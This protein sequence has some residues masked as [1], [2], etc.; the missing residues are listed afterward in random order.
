MTDSKGQCFTVNTIPN[1]NCLTAACEITITISNSSI[2][3]PYT[4][5][6]VPAGIQGVTSSNVFTLTNIPFLPNYNI[7]VSGTGSCSVFGQ[8]YYANP[9]A[10]ANIT[11]TQ[12]NVTCPG[13]NNGAAMAAFSGVGPY[14]WQW[15][16]GSTNASISGLPAGG[17]TVTISDSRH[18]VATRSFA[19]SEPA[20]ILSQFATTLIPCY[21]AK[22]NSTITTTGGSSPFSYTLNGQPVTGSLV[23]SLGAGVHTIQTRDG[24]GCARTAT[25]QLNQV[26]QQVITPTVASPS[27]PGDSDGSIG[28]SVSGPVT[29]YSYSWQPVSSTATMVTGLVPGH[30]TLEVTDASSCITTSVITLPPAASLTPFPLIK[31]ENCSAVDG[32]FTMMVSGGQAPYSYTTFPGNAGGNAVSGLSSGSYTTVIRD[33]R[34]CVDSVRF[35]L[36]NLSTVSLHIQTITAVQCYST[37][38]GSVLLNVQNGI[39]PVSYSLSGLPSTTNP[40]VSGLCSGRY[41]VRAIDNIG[42]PAFD[43]IYFPEPPAFSY[44]AQVPPTICVGRPAQLQGAASGGNGALTYIWTPGNHTGSVVS[45]SPAANSV[46]S[47]NVYDAK[48]CS[49]PSYTVMVTVNPPI[50][51]QISRSDAGICPGTTAQISPTVSGGDGNYTYLWQPGQDKSPSIFVQN[52]TVPVYTLTVNDACGSPPARKEIAIKLHP[53]TRPLYREEGH[54]GCMP[55]CATFINTTPGARDAVW[56]YGDKPSEQRGDTSFYCY[57][58]AGV[59]NLRLTVTDSNACRASYTYTG[60][61]EVLQRPR[62]GF[63]TEP[64]T[65]TLNNAENVLMKNTSREA[66]SFRWFVDDQFLGAERNERYT[67]RDTG[68]YTLK[69]VAGNINGC[70]DSTMRSICVFEGFNFYMP[71]AFTPNNDGINDILLPKGTGWLYENYSLEIYNRWG[72]RVFVTT[73]VHE[74]WDGVV[75]SDPFHL[76][77]IEAYMNDVYTW[78]VLVTDNMQQ[79][80]ELRGSVMVLR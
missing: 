19:I 16:T 25:L 68:C 51:I 66:S 74:G 17:Y 46:Y 27:C 75:L 53:V 21:G 61:V 38:N 55:Y 30:Y 33:S 69:L 20:D 54:G 59:Y 29:G 7:T 28:V 45:V 34:G 6:S 79:Q 18:C 48:G 65:I 26:S 71:N 35:F 37:C 78:R 9:T 13:G 8:V 39:L 40:A 42:C 43:T 67:F 49:L 15:S 57:E 70:M 12:T 22:V 36:G 32:A 5:T 44:S 50:D 2:S 77:V 47:L 76:E 62:A 58:A 63:I 4:I 14:T 80:H 11:I 72:H 56:N 31:R 23:A 73:N 10:P 3:P 24:K 60:A 1:F 64:G 41:A 52:I